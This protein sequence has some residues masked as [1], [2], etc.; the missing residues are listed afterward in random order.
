MKTNHSPLP[1]TPNKYGDLKDAN[2]ADVI[3]WALGIGHGP[4]SENAE[5]NAAFIVNAC[6]T[7]HD[8]VAACTLAL[9][10]IKD[11]WIAE[12]GNEQVGMAWGAL[13]SALAKVQA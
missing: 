7:H 4:R 13:E 12:H 10:L 8:L 6:N 1:W 2:N 5:A 9:A 3:T 11:T